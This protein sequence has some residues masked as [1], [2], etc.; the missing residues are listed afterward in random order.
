[1][2]ELTP[3]VVDALSGLKQDNYTR[4]SLI[5]LFNLGLN[6]LLTILDNIDEKK[7]RKTT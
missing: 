6:H 3:K 5:S 2:A 7:L 4:D 1:L